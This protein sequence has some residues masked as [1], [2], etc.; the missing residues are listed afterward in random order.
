MGNTSAVHCSTFIPKGQQYCGLDSEATSRAAEGTHTP[1]PYATL[2]ATREIMAHNS[3]FMHFLVYSL[4]HCH[5]IVHIVN[6]IEATVN[7]GTCTDMFTVIT[8]KDQPVIRQLIIICTVIQ[9]VRHVLALRDYLTQET[10][11]LSFPAGAVIT[12]GEREGLDKGE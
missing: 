4:I 1:V 9:N 8:T 7:T 11:L 2:R 10:S 6:N 12:L 3:L 5:I